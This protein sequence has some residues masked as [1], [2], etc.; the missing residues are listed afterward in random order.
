MT[1]SEPSTSADS[2]NADNSPEGG[3]NTADPLEL[4]TAVNED[5]N[6]DTTPD[7]NDIP[8]DKTDSSGKIP[9]DSKMSS[10]DPTG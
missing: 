4:T 6:D 5:E 2:V 7:D 10:T 3:A 1:S 8:S 9:M